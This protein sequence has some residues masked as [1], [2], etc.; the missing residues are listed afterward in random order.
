MVD[1]CTGSAL[2][3]GDNCAAFAGVKLGDEYVSLSAAFKHST[4]D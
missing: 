1:L 4:R 2:V 3:A